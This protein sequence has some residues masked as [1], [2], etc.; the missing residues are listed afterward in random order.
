MNCV[1]IADP[2]S[3]SEAE[4]AVDLGFN[5]YAFRAR[6]GERTV[7][8][9]DAAADFPESGERPSGNGS[10]LLFPFPNRINGGQY[11]WEGREYSL[12]H[13]P[14]MPH[15][16]HGFALDRPWRVIDR[17]PESVTGEFQISRDAP[18]R[19]ELWP[20]DGVIRVRY[21]VHQSTLALQ[22][23]IINP[24]DKPLP[25]GFGTHTYFKLPLAPGSDP[26]RCLV[27]AEA[28]EQWVLKE[29]IPTGERRAVSESADLRGGARF[30]D[31][32]LDDVLTGLHTEGSDH[33][34]VI[35][36]EAAGLEVVQA[37]G[38]EFRELVAFTPSWT[39][40]IC[41]E[42]YTCTTDAV[43]LEARGIDA[44]WKVL[45]P[46]EEWQ[47]WIQIVARPILV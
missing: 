3:G 23:A 5:C 15:A 29:A 44:G 38:V 8:V 43:N 31:L 9:I 1:T 24:D 10:P 19:L 22:V 45:G 40:A 21:S 41:L 30:G 27:A 32:K 26:G 42:P 25:F 46:G 36:D 12:P 18:E 2:V 47:S 7:D 13:R 39:T 6:V 34:T 11:T 33:E 16:I 20:A 4:I 37:F 28:A 17:T 35:M 14:G